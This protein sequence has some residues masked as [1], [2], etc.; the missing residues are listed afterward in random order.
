MSQHFHISHLVIPFIA[1]LN[2]F[3]FFIWALF[4]KSNNTVNQAFIS[5]DGSHIS[6]LDAWLIDSW[7]YV[8]TF[9]QCKNKNITELVYSQH[10]VV[11]NVFFCCCCSFEYVDILGFQAWW[12]IVFKGDFLPIFID[13]VEEILE[14]VIF[15][16]SQ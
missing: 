1:S 3:P 4:Y 10:L 16:A 14:F 7:N 13:S 15:P 8:P 5:T 11:I 9:W 2:T 6:I 12:Q